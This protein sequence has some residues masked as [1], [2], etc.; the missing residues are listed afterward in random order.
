MCSWCW[1]LYIAQYRSVSR[2][3]RRVLGSHLANNGVIFSSNMMRMLIRDSTNE[4]MIIT[5]LHVG[6]MVAGSDVLAGV[7][8]VVG[9][10]KSA[11]SV[12]WMAAKVINNWLIRLNW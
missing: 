3:L 10:K 4:A 8:A 9:R 11:A 1:S 6:N 12:P 7:V 5:V 2:W